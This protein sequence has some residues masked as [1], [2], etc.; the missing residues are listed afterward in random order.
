M[1]SLTQTQID[2]LVAKLQYYKYQVSFGDTILG[3]LNSAPQVEAD[4][5][6]QDTVLYE[7]GSDPQA[8]IISQNNAKIT[9]EC[10]DVDAAMA[11]LA[12]FKKG[13]NL[14]DSS[15]AKALVM[16]PLTD[17]AGAKTLTFENCYLQPGVATNFA[18]GDDP[19][20]ITLTFEAKPVVST[21]LLFTFA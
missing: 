3:P 16:V 7:T 20:Y 15:T 4:I 10:N 5:E 1:A 21:G 8:S 14:L 17:D 2:A 6:T 19:N 9:L 13:D 12:D 18:E 11:L